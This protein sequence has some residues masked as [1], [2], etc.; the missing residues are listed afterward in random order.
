MSI[1]RHQEPLT[2]DSY[3][4]TPFHISRPR[5]AGHGRL[6]PDILVDRH[7]L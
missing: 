7:G 4:R 3:S 5:S 1:A 6:N 2:G